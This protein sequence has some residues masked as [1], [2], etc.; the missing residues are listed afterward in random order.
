MSDIHDIRSLLHSARGEKGKSV[1]DHLVQVF[2]QLIYDNPRD[3]LTNLELVSQEVKENS[4]RYFREPL[5]KQQDLQHVLKYSAEAQSLIGRPKEENDEGVL[6]E[7]APEPLAYIPDLL[8]DRE[9]L[10]WAGID[11]GEDES[12]RLQNS[13]KKLMK[14][15]AARDIRFWGK[16]LGTEKDYYIVEGNGDAAEEEAERPSDFEKRGEGVNTYTYWV[17]DGAFGA[18]HELPDINPVH[19]KAAREIRKCFT[20]HLEAKVISNP[21]FPGTEKELLRTQIA[22]ITHSSILIQKGLFKTVEDAPTEVEAE[23]EPILQNTQS[24]KNISNW[25][26]QHPNILK[27]GRVSHMEPE[28]VDEEID[29]EVLK[30]QI[31]EADPLEDRLKPLDRDAAPAGFDSAWISRYLGDAQEYE[32]TFPIK[33]KV[34]YAVNVLRS[35]WWPGAVAVQQNG[36][37]LHFY[38][39][40]GMKSATKKYFPVRPPM[41]IDDPVD[42][43]E[44]KDPYPENKPEE[45]KEEVQED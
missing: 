16:I 22:R 24:L 39:G 25:V 43:Q 15:K 27:C 20:G 26:H 6:V 37:L 35:M 34:T 30:A 7:I 36:K 11:L 18:W 1:M 8:E 33:G 12:L 32:L 10:R 21:Y 2:A 17:T 29:I 5:N 28:P 9:L 41:I 13:L 42:R 3:P 19:I 23:E 45:A 44:V 40:D 38:L 4:F 31:L 14:E